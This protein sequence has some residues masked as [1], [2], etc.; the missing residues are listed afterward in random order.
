[1]SYSPDGR[2]VSI[3]NPNTSTRVISRSADGDTL[4]VTGTAVTPEF[5]AYGILT[6]GMRWS[7]T[8]QGETASSPRFA[9]RYENL[10][11]QTIREERS[12]FHGA[13]LST[14]HAYD[15]LGRPI[16]TS[17]DYE[18]TIE[19]TYDTLGNRVATTRSVVTGTTGVS[20]V[21]WRKSETRSS[22]I[23]DDSIVW[24][25]QTNIVSCSDSAIA[26]LATASALQLTGRTPALPSR[27]RSFDIRGNVTVHETLVDSSLVTSRQTVPYATNKPLSFSRYGVSLMD[28]SVSSVNNTVAYDA[29]GRQVASTDGRGN[30]RHSEYNS[31]GQ[32]SASIDALGNRTTY[33]YDQ[34]GDLA[35]VTDPLG[36]A[37]VYE[38]DLR[39]RK[40]Y[41]GGA[42]YPVRYT[43]DVFGNKV[44]MMTYRNESLGPDSGD[45]T[46]WL[47]DIA[48]GSM[49]NKVYAD[50]KGPTYSYTPDGK[51]SQRIWARGVVTD[52]TYDRWGNLTNT[53]Y[54]DATPTVSLFYD[55]MGRQIE[56][57]DAAGVTSYL[58]DSFG[59]LTNETVSGV[60]GTNTIIRH[61]DNYG[62]S[63]GY[64]LDSKVGCA[65]PSAP[66]RQ[67]TLSY[68]PAT[69]RLA[70]MLASGSETPFTWSYLA[71]SDLKSSLAYPNGLT[72]SWS[73]DVNSQLLQVCNAT[74]SNIISQYD[75]TYDSAGRR[76]NVSKTGTA[77]AQ[78]DSVAYGYNARS[79][80]TNAVAAIDAAYCY[81]YQ[82]DDIGNRATSS[83]R[84]TNVVYAANKLN[85]YT[86]V[87]DFIPQFDDD[88]NQ[89]LIKTVTGIWS[90]TYNG[91]NRPVRWKSG[92]AVIT[93]SFDRIGRR[94]AK[95]ERRFVYDDYLQIVDNNGNAY[96]WDP[97]ETVATRPLTWTKHQSPTISFYTHD[98][99]KNVSDVVDVNGTTTAHYDYAP[100]GAVI[101]SSGDSSA[102]NPWCFSSEFSEADLYLVYYNYRQYDHVA[103]RWLSR[104]PGGEASGL[105]LIAF[106]KN[107]ISIDV[108]GLEDCCCKVCVYSA[109]ERTH[110]GPGPLS[111][112]GDWRGHTWF[113][114][115]GC[116]TD[117]NGFV[118]VDE[119]NTFSFGPMSGGN[120][121]EALEIGVPSGCWDVSRYSDLK[122][123]KVVK[124]CYSLDSKKCKA[125]KDSMAKWYQP[126]FSLSTYCTTE[127][128]T[129]LI[130]HGIDVPKGEGEIE[131]SIFLPNQKCP[132]PKDMA[133][134]LLSKGGVELK[135]P[136]PTSST[137]KEGDKK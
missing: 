134:Q 62:R 100:F 129:F 19:Y 121:K 93:M 131:V 137:A 6:D 113:Q 92:D 27:S 125:I 89:T 30:T 102:A 87:D 66:Q 135:A 127:T 118:D 18:P 20:P 133:D 17:A 49:T 103:G 99:N 80:L 84:G 35:S 50:G 136:S 65:V 24:L 69:G 25:I 54:S 12:G 79:E 68:D 105:N 114:V 33:A 52:Y 104:D 45:I 111:L 78:N 119:E 32:H 77:F 70:T 8:V 74:P 47:Y 132:N 26:P 10:L 59:S 15:S 90:V 9:K 106:V 112:R 94:V 2:T 130:R 40:T 21:E 41:E 36:H 34:F 128:V 53:V 82:F 55:A 83:E 72:A 107:T 122:V 13:V 42:T 46:T 29:L 58:Y 4:S 76:I 123:Y 101:F 44:S 48:S 91:E 88:G 108:L 37:T 97:T 73:Y 16:S 86:V 5:H 96:V 126:N 81:S 98:G 61:W 64:S 85:Q 95:N 71:G 38:Y 116:N 3:L 110:S 43:Y 63:L 117:E 75:Y 11:D 23:L 60:A 57:H 120:S 14:T 109:I 1:M 67:S 115:E 28:V 56:A 124:K 7:R 22:F 31:L 51:L 39:G